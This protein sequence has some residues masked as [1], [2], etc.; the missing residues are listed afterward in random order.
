MVV[1]YVVACVTIWSTHY[2]IDMLSIYKLTYTFIFVFDVLFT[3][4]SIFLIGVTPLRDM[5]K[6]GFSLWFEQHN[7]FLNVT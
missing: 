1:I 2:S 4:T 3:I 5:Y 7:S 6:Y